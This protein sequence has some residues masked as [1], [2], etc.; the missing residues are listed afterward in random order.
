VHP[1]LSVS[2]AR[3]RARSIFSLTHKHTRAP[4]TMSSKIHCNTGNAYSATE[5][6]PIENAL[7]NSLQHTAMHCICNTCPWKYNFTHTEYIKNYRLQAISH[8]SKIEFIL[9]CKFDHDDWCCWDWPFF[10]NPWHVF[11]LRANRIYAW[12]RGRHS[13]RP[14]LFKCRIWE[15]IKQDCFSSKVERLVSFLFSLRRQCVGP[16]PLKVAAGIL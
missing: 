2:H 13:S 6:V 5:F 1:Y 4:T 10:L 9:I 14:V 11:L 7:S 8:S 16:C 3:A 12:A 15:R